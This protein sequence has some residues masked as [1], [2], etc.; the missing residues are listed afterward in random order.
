MGQAPKEL[1]QV[2]AEALA[3][4]ERPEAAQI[5]GAVQVEVPEFQVDPSTVQGILSLVAAFRF[6]VVSGEL[7]LS[8]EECLRGSGLSPAA[9]FARANRHRR[10]ESQLHLNLSARFF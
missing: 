3:K 2:L 7:H 6:V 5:R 9:E 8:A 10:E 4:L 1:R